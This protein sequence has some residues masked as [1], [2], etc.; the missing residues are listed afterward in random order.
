MAYKKIPLEEQLKRVSDRRR[1]H[2]EYDACAVQAFGM[3]PLRD[4]MKSSHHTQRLGMILRV[5]PERLEKMTVREVAVLI[6][7][8]KRPG[9]G[10]LPFSELLLLFAAPMDGAYRLW[11]EAQDAKK[12][13]A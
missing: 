5:P 11:K 4:Y 7:R 13:E 10:V 6:S 3:M 9:P 1:I 12:E 2:P 8:K